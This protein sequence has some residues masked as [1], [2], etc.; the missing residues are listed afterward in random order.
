MS[1]IPKC[2]AKTAILGENRTVGV[3]GRTPAR[4]SESASE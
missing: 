1:Q 4:V 3:W 2:R